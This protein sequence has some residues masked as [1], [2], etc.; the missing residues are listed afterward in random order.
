M[1][2]NE[3]AEVEREARAEALKPDKAK[4]NDWADRIGAVES[5]DVKDEWFIGY[6]QDIEGRLDRIRLDIMD[7]AEGQ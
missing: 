7:T 3:K 1:K 4:L 2:A 6:V 5:P